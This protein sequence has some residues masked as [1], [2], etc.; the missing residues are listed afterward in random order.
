MNE[1]LIRWN[2]NTME[3]KNVK[4]VP[5]FLLVVGYFFIKLKDSIIHPLKGIPIPNF[6]NQYEETML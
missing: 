3:M 1:P 6:N 5:V 4:K 2:Q